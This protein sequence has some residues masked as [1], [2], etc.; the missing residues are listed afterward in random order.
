[1]NNQKRIGLIVA[2]IGLILFLIS[3]TIETPWNS[4][5]SLFDSSDNYQENI[6]LKRV[7]QYSGIILLLFGVLMLI[8]EKFRTRMIIGIGLMLLGGYLVI[9]SGYAI[10]HY[11]TASDRELVA[12]TRQAINENPNSQPQIQNLSNRQLKKIVRDGKKFVY[13]SNTITLVLGAGAI[14]WGL[15]LFRKDRRGQYLL[16]NEMVSNS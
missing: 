9:F 12:E 13:I 4:G 10:V 15:Y 2:V 5:A 3:Q 7:V 1:M 6:F 16:A 11:L 14:L 8:I